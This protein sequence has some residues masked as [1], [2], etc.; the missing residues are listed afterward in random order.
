[1]LG[2]RGVEK[3]VLVDLKGSRSGTQITLPRLEDTPD[4]DCDVLGTPFLP[5]PLFHGMAGD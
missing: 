4:V 1:M 3:E 2:E 5:P